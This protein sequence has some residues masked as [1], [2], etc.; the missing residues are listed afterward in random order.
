MVSILRSCAHIHIRS[1][2]SHEYQSTSISRSRS[3][4]RS[5]DRRPPDSRDKQIRSS[6]RPRSASRSLSRSRSPRRQ[7]LYGASRRYD[8]SR[9]RSPRRRRSGSPRNDRRLNE[10]DETVTDT[11]I[12]AVAA[13]VKGHGVKYAETLKEREKNNPKYA[14]LVH[15]DVSRSLILQSRPSLLIK[16]V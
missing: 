10:E 6:N 2:V 15:K 5:R 11:F 1:A 16:C 8:D 14:F 12:R 4:S 7:K 9:S 3:R 13:E